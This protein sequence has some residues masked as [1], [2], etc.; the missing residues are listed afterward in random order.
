MAR[1][2]ITGSTDGLGLA[3]ARTL[4]DDGHRVVLHARSSTRASDLSTKLGPIVIG[5]GARVGANAV[6][7]DPVLD[8]VT[9]VGIPARPPGQPCADPTA[10]YGIAPGQA[11]PVAE[12]IAALRAE[13]AALRER[14]SLKA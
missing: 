4:V 6:C 12:Q 10:G 3:A 1:V 5:R 14:T 11:D 7:V 9:V 8:G 13:I 2:F